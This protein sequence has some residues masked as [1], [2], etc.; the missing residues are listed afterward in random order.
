MCGRGISSLQG[1]YLHRISEHTKLYISIN[2]AVLV[3]M[4]SMSEQSQTSAP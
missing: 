3:P 2:N 1:L 4:I